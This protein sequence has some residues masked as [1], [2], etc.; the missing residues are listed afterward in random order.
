MI[1][2]ISQ[3]IVNSVLTKLKLTKG[4]IDLSNFLEFIIFNGIHEP[5]FNDWVI[6]PELWSEWCEK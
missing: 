5:D 3:E 2:T 6:I 4:E 1:V